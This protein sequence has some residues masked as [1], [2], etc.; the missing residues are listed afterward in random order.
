MISTFFGAG[1]LLR[2]LLVLLGS[3]LCGSAALAAEL[4]PYLQTPTANSIWVTWKTEEGSESVVEFG[5]DG[6]PLL[7]RATGAP[8]VLAANYRL[9]GVQLTGLQPETIYSYRVRTGSQVSPVYRF[10]TQPTAA[11]K[12]GHFRIL[13][14]GDHQLRNDDRHTPLLKAAK[15]KIESMTGLPLEESVQLML[16]NGDQ[17][18]VGTLDH[19]EFVHMKPSS[20]VSGNLAIMMALGNHE[21]YYDPG[22]VNWR[23]HTEYDKI[24][25]QGIPAA[26][27]ES[28]YAH[29]VGRVLLVYTNSEHSFAAQTEWLR[30]VV[31]AANADPDVDW[32]ISVVHRPYQAEQYVGDI[33]SWF[34]DTAMPI[35]A[36]T[37]KHVL[38]IGAHHHLY[39]RGQTRDWPVYHL[40]SGGTAWDQFWGQS[41][42]RDMDDV[43]KTI[44]NWTWQL[45]DFDLGARTMKVSSYAVGHPKLGFAYDNR[46]VDEFERHLDAAPPLQPVLDGVSDGATLSLPHAF[47]LGGYQS[48][49]GMALN[50]TQ[51]QIARDAAFSSKVVDLIRDVENLY[52]DS[53]APHYEPV[54]IHAGL[55]IERYAVGPNGLNN[56]RYYIRARHRDANAE[57][58][59]WTP[60]YS[61]TVQGSSD[62]DPALRLAKKVW[63]AAEPVVIEHL[64]GRGKP[65]DWVG[66]YRKSQKP[67]A[68]S[69]A[70]KWAYVSGANGRLSF[71]GLAAGVEYYAAFFTDD[72]FTEIAPR[73]AF[74]VGSPAT[75]SINKTQFNVGERPSIGWSGAPGGA[76]DWIG[77]YRVGQEPGAVG[78]TSWAYAPSAAGNVSLG[79]LDKGY[80]YASFMINDAYFEISERLPFAVGSEIASVSLVKTALA[81]GERLEIRFADG[82]ATAKDYIGVFRKGA[83]PG[84]D[85]LVSYSYVDGRASGSLSPTEALPDGEYFLALYIN[86]S[87]TEVSNRVAFTVGA[88][89]EPP[90]PPRVLGVA[91]NL[92]RTGETLNVSWSG[93]PGGAKD[94]V[95]VYRA[96]QTPGSGSPA[97]QWRYAAGAAG[98]TAFSGL[99]AGEYYIAFLLNDGYQEAAP[100]VPFAVRKL[101]DINGDGLIN[102]SDR[103]LQRAALGSCEGDTRYQPL[104]NFD[105]DKCITQADYK[106]WYALFTRQ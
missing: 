88:G 20:V 89:S 25:Y 8:Q 19:Y 73:A 90:P 46:L 49:S 38:N 16:N 59:P 95:G 47:K 104:A 41:T 52:G 18:D 37:R 82:P 4:Q 15:A 2:A 102:A 86:D 54:D 77:I 56:G 100:R 28:Y 45:I 78:S 7:R 29:Q 42:E 34:R 44:A 21:T 81:S 71:S 101:G 72:S 99:G 53:G 3:L 22:L 30:K 51:F 93:M 48:P 36:G 33:S 91:R 74:Y 50:S 32:V 62:G 23:A 94:W 85:L 14:T 12:S 79:A 69:P 24:S 10:R 60:T 27:D 92:I 11:R 68:G 40:I 17:V 103:D 63:P 65:K 6:G 80:Y 66:I 76:K 96:T 58:S 67:G 61:F 105:G 13:V 35:L 5:P 64:N 43:Q 31:A 75:L 39:A 83:K 26:A 106:L 87:Y 98:S 1:R 57:W 70:V 55:D 97:L 9:H 84:I